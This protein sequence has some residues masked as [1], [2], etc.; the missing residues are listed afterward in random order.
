[1]QIHYGYDNSHRSPLKPIV[2]VA[3]AVAV[4]AFLVFYI[5]L[6]SKAYDPC[7]TKFDYNQDGKAG[8]SKDKTVCLKMYYSGREAEAPK[9]PTPSF[10]WW[11]W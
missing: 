7:G 11:F 9:P 10:K 4:I 2:L 8:D 1:M 6:N 3:V 5:Q